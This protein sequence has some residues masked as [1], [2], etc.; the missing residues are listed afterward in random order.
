MR[1]ALHTFEAG[2]QDLDDFLADAER[3]G[4]L[5]GL[6]L[7]ETSLSALDEEEQK[8]LREQSA[9]RTDRKRY[10]YAVAI[11]S[12]YGVLERLVDTVIE[13]YVAVLAQ[14]ASKF[15]DLPDAIQKHHTALSIELLKAIIEDRFKRDTTQEGVISNLHSCASGSAEF[16]L[17]GPAFVLH[18]GNITLAKITSFLTSVGVDKHLRKVLLTNAF[19][20]FLAQSDPERDLQ[21][22][23]DQE[24]KTI[25]Q[26]IDDLVERR[27]QVSHGVIDVDDIEAVALL[28]D[29]CRLIRAYGNAL[30]EILLQEI[31]AS[32]LTKDGVLFL[33]KPIAVFNKSIACFESDCARI[34]EGDIMVAKVTDALLPFRFG[35]IRSIEIDKV[36]HQEINL[37]ILTRFGTALPF[38]TRHDYDHFVLPRE[39]V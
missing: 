5:I 30:Y 37:T 21:Q 14:H 10:I 32:E 31:L 15:A 29:R 7:R 16:K 17:N 34:A 23:S 25:L 35:R 26:P 18:R 8:L 22:T 27:N 6:L 20:M 24:L 36:R 9:S 11:V 2:I 39:S 13:R 1:T 38:R 12:L 28:R 4:I 19:S 3:E 33:G